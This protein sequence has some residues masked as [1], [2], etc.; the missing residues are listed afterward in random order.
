MVHTRGQQAGAVSSANH[1]SSA[2]VGDSVAFQATNMA[3]FGLKNGSTMKS[4]RPEVVRN[5]R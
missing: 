5:S 4:L 1:G 2:A 3:S